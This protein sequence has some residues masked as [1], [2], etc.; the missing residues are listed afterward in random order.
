MKM[1][2]D[3]DYRI[4]I[5]KDAPYHFIA[6]EPQVLLKYMSYVVIDRVRY[7]RPG[8]DSKEIQNYYYFIIKNRMKITEIKMLDG[9]HFYLKEGQYHSYDT[10][11]Y[12]DPGMKSINYAI[13]G[14]VL[15]QEESRRFVLRK[16]LVKLIK[17]SK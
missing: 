3:I 6:C 8:E 16:K 15:S 9:K 7:D 17:R 14:N 12:Y 4:T 5:I 13:N 1:R 10:Y 2:L 11:C